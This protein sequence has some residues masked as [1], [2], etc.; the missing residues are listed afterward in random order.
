MTVYLINGK[1]HT[2]TSNGFEPIPDSMYYMM[3]EEGLQPEME[4]I[5]HD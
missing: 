3:L 2:A 4:V 1:A 5:D